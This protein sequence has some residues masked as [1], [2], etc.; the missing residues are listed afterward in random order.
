CWVLSTAAGSCA[1]PTT[2]RCAAPSPQPPAPK[3]GPASRSTPC[4]SEP[5]V[6]DPEFGERRSE[7]RG[8]PRGAGGAQAPVKGRDGPVR[9]LVDAPGEE[10]RLEGRA[11]EIRG[12]EDV[13]VERQVR[14]AIGP[15]AGRSIGATVEDE[16]PA[17]FEVRIVHVEHDLHEHLVP[18]TFEG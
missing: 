8:C 7:V 10:V 6:G 15:S 18:A 13:D 4:A 5:N 1:L 16:A 3:Q 9:V 11:P 2:R 17:P 14:L 12:A